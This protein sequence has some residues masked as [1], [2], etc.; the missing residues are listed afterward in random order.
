MNVSIDAVGKMTMN[1]DYVNRSKFVRV[2]TV[3]EG[4]S[5]ITA[6]PFGHGAY[7]NPI[8]VGGSESMYLQ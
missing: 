3:A 4:A 2:E 7:T 1:G 5:P 8:F 6:V